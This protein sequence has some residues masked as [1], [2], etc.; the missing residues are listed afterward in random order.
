MDKLI[1]AFREGGWGMWPTLIFGTLA[2]AIAVRHAI[3]PR[4]ELLPLIVGLGI[5]TVFSG[6]LGLSVGVMTTIRY[7]RGVPEADRGLI[8]MIGVG[9]SLNNIAFALIL[10][11]LISL[12]GTV[13]AWRAR[14]LGGA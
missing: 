8:A 13:G 9:E 6:V 1:W 12:F 11:V 7:I 4:R 3:R 5:A 14:I 2:L 10:A